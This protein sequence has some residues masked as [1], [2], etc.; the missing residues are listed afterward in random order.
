[1]QAVVLDILGETAGDDITI[2]WD[3]LL[4]GAAFPANSTFK[5]VA[6]LIEDPTKE[7]AVVATISGQEI[8][9]P[10]PKADTVIA[11]LYKYKLVE[12]TAAPAKQRTPAR[13]KFEL[14]GVPVEG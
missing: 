12:T 4:D 11:G 2:I 7:I 13:G 1:M 3:L 8:T 5:F 6:E 9:A 10:I 14:I